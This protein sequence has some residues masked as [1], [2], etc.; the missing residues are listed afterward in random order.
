MTNSIAAVRAHFLTRLAKKQIIVTPG[1][2]DAL[3]ARI[4]ESLGYEALFLSGS[5]MSYSQLGQPDIGLVSMPELAD[6]VAR[7]T[8]RVSIPVLADVDSAFGAAP[9]AARLM[10]QFEKAGAAAVQM[11]D[12]VVV[13]AN[14]A[15]QSRPLV[16]ID[17]MTGKIKA[18][19]DAREY[20]ETL[21]SARSDA[22][23][24]DEAIE[25][26]VAYKD[27]GADI[28]FAEGMTKA[29][30]LKRLIAAVGEDMPVVYNTIYPDGDA[31]DAA[32]LEKLGVRMALFPG[33]ALQSA[34]AG[35]MAS[36]R[37]LKS[38]PSLSGGAKSPMPGPDLLELL[39]AG[40]F[41]DKYEAF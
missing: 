18:M 29:D 21:I 11:E 8:D 4:A 26:C 30:D 41:I 7:I 10:R 35:M 15:L 23:D 32:A 13:K 3:S 27:A 38:D 5:A 28:V 2:F 6:A 36:L 16:S 31:T 24:A 12:Q 9:H 39:E 1:V 25:R 34:A 14:D 22:K 20:A 17:E 37:K 33:L 40:A 19:T